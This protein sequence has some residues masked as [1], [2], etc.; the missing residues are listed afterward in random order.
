MIET[1]K[2]QLEN[3]QIN[4]QES[5]ERLA[6]CG[7]ATLGDETLQELQ[8]IEQDSNMLE[9][10]E[11][12]FTDRKTIKNHFT[13]ELKA[14][15][16]VDDKYFIEIYENIGITYLKNGQREPMARAKL[17]QEV[18][19]DKKHVPVS[20]IEMEYAKDESKYILDILSK[21]N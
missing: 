1:V 19:G 16:V 12:Y 11:S 14:N 21:V 4:D 7:L 17:Y 3:R 6:L 18:L 10:I 9:L 15:L 13:P 2:Q 5:R 8:R 20:M